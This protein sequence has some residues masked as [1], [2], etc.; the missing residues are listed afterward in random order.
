MI[1]GVELKTLITYPDERGFFREVLRGSDDIMEDGF[2]QWSHSHMHPGVAKAWHLHAYHT[3]L[4]Y[5]VTGRLKVAL[6]DLRFGKL[7]RDEISTNLLPLA[8]KWKMVLSHIKTSDTL[9][10]LQEYILGDEPAILQIPAG[11]AHGCKA[12]SEV[13]MMYITSREYDGTDELR[14]AHDDT[15]IGYDWTKGVEIT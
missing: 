10:E 3:D 13:H 1:D 8:K 5:V 14:I 7:R 9:G 12:L 6:F 11:V 15:E 4:W 2:A